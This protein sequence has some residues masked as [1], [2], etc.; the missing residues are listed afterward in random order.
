MSRYEISYWRVVDG[1][2]RR[3]TRTVSSEK[4]K[5]SALATVPRDAE[6]LAVKPLAPE[7]DERTT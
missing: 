7:P 3:T 1:T 2:R 5:L 6:D 4:S